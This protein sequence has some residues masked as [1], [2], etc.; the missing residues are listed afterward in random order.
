[1]YSK[2]F[3]NSSDYL[4][5]FAI[6]FFVIFSQVIYLVLVYDSTHSVIHT[7]CIKSSYEHKRY[8]FMFNDEL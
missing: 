1:M 3:Q 7:E 8:S 6:N 5:A 2:M 4:S